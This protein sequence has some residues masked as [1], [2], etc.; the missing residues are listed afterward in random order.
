MQSFLAVKYS[1]CCF[2]IINIASPPGIINQ[3][4]VLGAILF[5]QYSSK[6][7]KIQRKIQA[8]NYIL[9]QTNF[10][11]LIQKKYVLIS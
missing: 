2:I 8:K 9:I 7:R 3:K 11:I 1:N 4:F 6:A 10:F 5:L